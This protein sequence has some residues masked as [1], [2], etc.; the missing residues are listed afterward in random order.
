MHTLNVLLVLVA[1][2]LILGIGFAL[3]DSSRGTG[4]SA[5]AR[6]DAE[7]DRL[8]AARDP[9]AYTDTRPEAL[10][11]LWTNE[12]ARR[13]QGF[14]Y[15]P[16]VQFAHWPF[17]SSTLNLDARGFC[18]TPG[19]SAHPTAE[20]VWVFGGSTVLGSGVDDA[21]TIPVQL[22]AGLGA[23][24]RVSNFG[25]NYFYSSQELA[26]FASM[27]RAG[28]RPRVAVFVDGLNDTYQLS[29]G[30]DRPW[31]SGALR[32]AWNAENGWASRRAPSR[33]P[34]LRAADALRRRLGPEA[35]TQPASLEA[36]PDASP[37]GF[38]LARYRANQRMIRAI[39]REYGVMRLFVWQ[40]VPFH[41][42]DRSLQPAHTI[43]PER[44]PGF[45]AKVYTEM[46]RSRAA[47]QLY[48]G[49]LLSEET[50]NVYVDGVH[51]NETVNGRIA[52]AILAALTNA[53][54]R[55]EP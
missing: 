12:E 40:P 34:M 55:G 36:V 1:V 53:L 22:Q 19:A 10:P 51:Y 9:S 30:V 26:L 8:R 31:F 20:A 29:R 42:Y 43:Y 15:R 47:D 33:V 16:W 11:E 13:G 50:R 32:A 5:D 25:Q 27:L 3:R 14:A 41:A 35:P 23:G 7:R 37:A 28:E 6:R 21:H 54:E 49:D 48:L 17:G 45:W 39:C 24:Y 46:A 2:N 18:T 44:V 52:D 38:V 4:L